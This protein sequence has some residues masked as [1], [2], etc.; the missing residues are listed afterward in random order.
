MLLYLKYNSNLKTAIKVVT[1][2][3]ANDYYDKEI[4][5]III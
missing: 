3:K 2:F 5:I 1:T 4:Y